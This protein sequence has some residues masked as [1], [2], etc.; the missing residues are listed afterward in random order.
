MYAVVT[1]RFV[2]KNRSLPN[3]IMMCKICAS[4]VSCGSGEMV[5]GASGG[6]V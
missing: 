3:E 2:D 6:G 5:S 1:E 4:N